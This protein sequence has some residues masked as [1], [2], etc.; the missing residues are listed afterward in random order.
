V[1]LEA[2]WD[3][4]EFIKASIANVESATWWAA[5]GGVCPALLP[6]QLSS[7]LIIGVA[8]PVSVIAT[9]ALMYFNGFTLNTVSFG[10]L[11][12]GVG[13]LVDNSIVVLE[14]IF[15]HREEGQSNMQAAIRAPTK[16][17]WRSPP[18]P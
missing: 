7:T 5:A 16:W 18:P 9:F 6:A 2:T 15:R 8:I 11:A 14:N 1:T 10:G 4:A 3:S 17:P 12:L 13:M